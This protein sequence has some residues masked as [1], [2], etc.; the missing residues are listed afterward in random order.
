MLHFNR[1]LTSL[2]PSSLFQDF[3]AGAPS[4]LSFDETEK[5]G[6][7]F[8]PINRNHTYRQRKYLFFKDERVRMSSWAVTVRINIHVVMRSI[9][10]LQSTGRTVSIGRKH[11]VEWHSALQ[12]R[13]VLSRNLL[14][15]AKPPKNSLKM[16]SALL[17]ICLIRC[18][19]C[20]VH[21]ANAWLRW[22]IEGIPHV[23]THNNHH[24]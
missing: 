23:H 14:S 4:D 10:Q 8:H 15:W 20:P 3:I 19:A 22:S 21:W 2:K 5:Q 1:A 9:P 7:V 12:E 16:T 17:F 24:W 11:I 18:H 6:H 13:K